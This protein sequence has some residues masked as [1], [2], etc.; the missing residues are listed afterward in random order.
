MEMYNR[1]STVIRKVALNRAIIGYDTEQKRQNIVH[2]QPHN[3]K[4]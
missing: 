3:V 1:I 4:L 2:T